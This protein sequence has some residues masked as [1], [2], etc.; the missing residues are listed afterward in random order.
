MGNSGVHSPEPTAAACGSHGGTKGT[1]PMVKTS[2]MINF[3]GILA[4]VVILP[5]IVIP[6]HV[7]LAFFSGVCGGF[8]RW[9]IEKSR[10]W[11]AGLLTMLAGGI[12]AMFM[13][14]AGQA[15]FSEY[16]PVGNMDQHTATMFGGFIAGVLGVGLVGIFL[17]FAKGIKRREPGSSG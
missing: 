7:P 16:L 6:E 13:W 8:I 3:A 11:P 4:G 14:P 10:W 15:V 5:E 2:M 1:A 9:V 12:I 17:D